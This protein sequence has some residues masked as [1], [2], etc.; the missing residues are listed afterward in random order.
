MSK[1]YILQN[2][3][4]V[5]DGPPARLMFAPKKSRWQERLT[6]IQQNEV[7]KALS[8]CPVGMW[9]GVACGC[10]THSDEAEAAA[11]MPATVGALGLTIQTPD[12]PRLASQ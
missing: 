9:R 3:E 6:R 8:N 5:R 2:T 11:E 7:G 10:I 4:S 12:S 1:L